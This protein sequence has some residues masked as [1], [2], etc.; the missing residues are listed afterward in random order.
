MRPG[1]REIT[2]LLGNQDNQAELLRKLCP[3]RYPSFASARREKNKISLIEKNWDWSISSNLIRKLWT[4][5]KGGGY[6]QRSQD[7][8]D[9]LESLAQKNGINLSRK[10]RPGEI[11]QREE[12]IA[13]AKLS[14]SQ[15]ELDSHGSHAKAALLRRRYTQKR[16]DLIEALIVQKYSFVVPTLSHRK[17]ID[18][19]IHRQP[20]DQKVSSVPL[21]YKKELEGKIEEKNINEYIKSHPEEIVRW[22]YE[23]QDSARFGSEDRLL[24][25]NLSEEE[26]YRKIVLALDSIDF[27]NKIDVSFSYDLGSGSQTYSSEA[28][29][30]WVE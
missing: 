18:W 3:Q 8:L 19:M 15:K 24:I 29:V 16:N 30:A 20:F 26:N 1:N 23:N 6:I 22:L 9:A 13:R 27:D 2:A 11:S 5:K 4:E 25:V 28:I 21:G 10:Y 17:G 12:S 7:E 14:L